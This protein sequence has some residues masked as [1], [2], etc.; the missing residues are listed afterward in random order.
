MS[1]VGQ[2]RRLMGTRIGDA[3]YSTKTVNWVVN[4]GAATYSNVEQ[5]LELAP[6]GSQ[7]EWSVWR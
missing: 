1:E 7:L 3:A 6:A 5:L 2:L 4:Q